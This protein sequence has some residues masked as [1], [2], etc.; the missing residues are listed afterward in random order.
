MRT[1][2]LKSKPAPKP[3]PKATP[4]PTKYGA[5]IPTHLRNFIVLE[6]RD[7]NPINEDREALFENAILNNYY[8]LIQSLIDSKILNETTYYF[9]CRDTPDKRIHRPLGGKYDN[10]YT[11]PWAHEND[12]FIRRTNHVNNYQ[13]CKTAHVALQMAA[14]Y[15]NLKSYMMIEDALERIPEGL[16]KDVLSNRLITEASVIAI[17][18]D[19]IELFDHIRKYDETNNEYLIYRAQSL[20]VI[21]KFMKNASHRERKRLLKYSESDSLGFTLCSFRRWDLF[22][23]LVPKET[24]LHYVGYGIIFGFTQLL[25]Q[26]NLDDLAES[27]VS[28]P[29]DIIVDMKGNIRDADTLIRTFTWLKQLMPDFMKSIPENLLVRYFTP[30]FIDWYLANG[31][32]ITSELADMFLD[33]IFDIAKK[34]GYPSVEGATWEACLCKLRDLGIKF[35]MRVLFAEYYFW[36]DDD[37]NH[38]GDGCGGKLDDMLQRYP[39]HFTLNATVGDFEED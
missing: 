20:N 13:I 6:P 31:Y 26:F 30:E 28:I 21:E 24:W 19:E 18:R 15:G 22:Q 16:E 33:S 38:G 9:T 8:R 25:D 39:E 3:A 23:A 35:G 37:R 12:T 5:Y 17:C 11:Y 34:Y 10:G 27:P 2:K 29:N 14:R 36:D 4:K 1:A 32:E 7:G